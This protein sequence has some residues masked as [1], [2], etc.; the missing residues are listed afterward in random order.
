MAQHTT[1]TV[2]R[3]KSI[4]TVVKR[5]T[6]ISTLPQVALKVIEVAKDPDA[7]AADL[8]AVV[9]GDPALS[10]RV[11]RMVNSAA[12]GVSST[13][14][15][16]HQAISYLGFNQVRNLAMTASVSELFKKKESLGPYQR[17]Q[18]WRHM[19][20]VGLCAKLVASR[21]RMPNFDDAFLAGLLHDIGLILEDQHTH[22]QF[23]AIMNDIHDGVSLID[24]EKEYLGFNHCVLGE[25]VAEAWR[26]PDVVQAAIRH[27]HASASYKGPGLD[28]VQCVEVANVICTIKG[29]TS[30]G[31]KLV[32]PQLETFLSM[33]FQ[34]EDILI[35]AKDLDAELSSNETLF[36]L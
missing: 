7:G 19:V 22:P 17:C 16:L 26:F 10:S 30:V 6:E 34:K 35:L 32:K 27:H 12:Y 18:L 20:S 1:A 15:S 23:V 13:V 28:I 4:D 33:G 9:E 21:R 29:I 5:I 14:T 25:R 3:P 24:V 2:E 36:E 8:K 11:L 31:L